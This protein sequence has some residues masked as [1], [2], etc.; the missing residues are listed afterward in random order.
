M[1][2]DLGVRTGRH[3][4]QNDVKSRVVCETCLPA[5]DDA[6]SEIRRS[7]ALH[8]VAQQHLGGG[9]TRPSGNPEH[10]TEGQ[11]PRLASHPLLQ[12]GGLK[13]HDRARKQ[14]L[15]SRRRF[16]RVGANYWEC[17]EVHWMLSLAL[18]RSTA[19]QCTK[20]DE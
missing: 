6:A 4:H 17:S 16:R 1:Y 7:L 14:G 10:V 9:I 8:D 3:S 18:C 15:F 13:G 11:L 2:Q 19:T 12:K 20:R 5:V